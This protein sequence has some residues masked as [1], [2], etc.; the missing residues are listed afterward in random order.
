MFSPK[1]IVWGGVASTFGSLM[2]LFQALIGRGAE[3]GFPLAFLLTMGGLAT[4]YARHGKQANAL[5][6]AGWE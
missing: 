2:W 4:L 1:V 5:G 3:I 6:S